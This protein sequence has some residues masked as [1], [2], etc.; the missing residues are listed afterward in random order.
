MTKEEINDMTRV[1][2][3]DRIRAA[4]KAVLE[5]V[6]EE[7]LADHHPQVG[8]RGAASRENR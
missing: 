4:A 6:I 5:Q 7:E 2:V 8:T 3:G 1:A